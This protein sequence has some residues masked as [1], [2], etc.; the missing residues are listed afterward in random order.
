MKKKKF[1]HIVNQ[2]IEKSDIILE[3][4]DS[5]FITETR[6]KEIE[7][8]VKKNGKQLIYVINKCDLMPK[9]K[10]VRL[11]PSVFISAKQKLGT[12]KLLKL[13]LRFAKKEKNIVGVLGYP[14]TGKSS[15]INALKGRHSAGTSPFS[16]FTRG[17]QL[18]KVSNK[19][20]LLDSPGVFQYQEKDSFKLS[21]I[22][23]I[24]PSKIKNP[25]A[26][27]EELMKRFKEIIEKHYNVERKTFEK[28]L[29]KIA[30]KNHQLMKGGLPDTKR[31]AR[32]ILQDWQKGKIKL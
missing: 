17:K 7:D 16:G 11:S 18:L 1:W 12:T 15:V 27:V 30:L 9:K 19:L 22:S 2:I 23:S 32:I 29:E 24:D 5:R 10:I 20:Y 28:T 6:N 3:V 13:I 21:L 4:L 25:E 31:M 26:I 14:N 8:K